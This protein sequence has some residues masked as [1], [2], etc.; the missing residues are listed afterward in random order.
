[1]EEKEWQENQRALYEER[2]A[3]SS[4]RLRSLAEDTGLKEEVSEYFRTVASFL[5]Q[6]EEVFQ[7]LESGEWEKKTLQ[8]MQEVNESLYRDLLGEH[9][10]KAGQIRLLQKKSWENTVLF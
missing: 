9:Y 5:V 10:A 3:L 4:Q 2:Y 6:T 1:M 8:E 7:M